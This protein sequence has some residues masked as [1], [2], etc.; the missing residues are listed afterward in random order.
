MGIFEVLRRRVTIEAARAGYGIRR[1]NTPPY[2]WELFSAN[3]HES[4]VSGAALVHLERWLADRRANTS[5]GTS[6]GNGGDGDTPVLRLAS[7]DRPWAGSEEYEQARAEFRG[8]ATVWEEAGEPQSGPILEQ[9][10]AAR[11]R[12]LCATRPE[13]VNSEV[14]VGTTTTGKHGFTAPPCVSD[15]N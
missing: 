14:H 3:E 5:N 4:V 13:A 2:G 6:N 12:Y 1:R 9:L 10:A 11:E 15:P 8:A 7:T